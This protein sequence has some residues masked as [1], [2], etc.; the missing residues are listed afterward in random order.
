MRFLL[1]LAASALCAAPLCAGGSVALRAGTIHTSDGAVHTG[2]AVV[3]VVDGKIVA[4]GKDVAVPAGLRV[5]DYGPEAVIVPGLVAADSAYGSG[6]GSGRTADL[7]V[8]AVEGFDQHES[9]YFALQQGVTSAYIAPARGRLVAG[10]GAV[11]KLAGPIGPERVVSESAAVH[12]T[13]TAEARSVRGW[14]EPPIPATI[15]VGLGMEQAQLPKSLMGA[16]VALQELV[17]LG[18]GEDV[19][20]LEAEYG[21]DLRAGL[22]EVLERK[23]PW[24]IGADSVE[25]IRA[26]IAFAAESGL[27][28]ILDGANQAA[29]VADEIAKSGLAVVV[30]ADYAP[31][32]APRDQGKDE[33][34][35]WRRYDA[36]AELA[37]RGVKVALAPAPSMGAHDTRFAATLLRRGGLSADDAL[38]GVTR[39]AAEV[40]GVGRR[41]GRL[42]PGFD[43]D[44]AVFAG[45]PME[46]G[47][48]ALAT[49]ID[50]ELAFSAADRDAAREPGERYRSGAIVLSVDELHVG[51]GTVLAPGELLMRDGRIVEVGRK[52][53]R[54][55]GA[56][57]V[58]GKAAMPGMIDALGHLGLEGSN[59]GP[60]PR[61]SLARVVEPGDLVD[62]KV[63][64]AGVTT[65]GLTPR[66]GSRGGIPVMAYKPAA[67]DLSVQVV[68]DPCAVRLSWSA[69]NRRESGRNIVETLKKAADYDKKWSE[70]EQK[71]AAYTPPKAE[72]PPPPL[73]EKKKEEA[74]KD[75]EEKKDEA[76][77]AEGEKKEEPK[78][79]DKKKKKGEEEPPKPVTG[80]W[81]GKLALDGAEARI[82][83]LLVEEAGKV[84]GSLRCD[85][86]SADLVSVSG[87]REGHKAP[88]AGACAA[89]AVAVEG[90]AKDGKWKAKVSVGA[91]SA[92]VELAQTATEVL[93]ARRTEQ[94]KEKEEKKDE[95]KGAPKAPGVD[96]ELEPLRRAMLGEAAV[97][98]AVQREDEILACVD[99]FEAHGIQP[100][101]VGAEDAWKVLDR[102]QGRVAGVLLS[103]RIQ[104]VDP[105][106]GLEPINRYEQLA[107][108]G[109]PVAFHSLAEEGAADLPLMAAY[110]VSQGMG[111]AAALRA[112]TSDAARILAID[113]K[114]GL[115]QP[116]MDADVLLL[117]G[118][119]LEPATSVLRAFV[120]GKEIR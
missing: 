85:L 42:A 24:R 38:L 3:V 29:L 74:K 6:Q 28:I 45:H 117:D 101:L 77:S 34:A 33:A 82:R 71:L 53:G 19:A 30:E 84:E 15:D 104:Y 79:E 93:V 91:K 4:V 26:L 52:V 37:R 17:R 44:V 14:W 97:L 41:L 72:P 57:V 78:K 16:I 21:P 61:Q 111:P 65:V 118:A 10:H 32:S 8:K 31:N 73:P 64:M 39:N 5:V 60:A 109:I 83:L 108:A 92:E 116:G 49:W 67:D 46:S 81:E 63:A 95:P 86:V 55:S 102:I 62:R 96:P 119:P 51:D 36:A 23:T 106:R 69:G 27:P 113:D 66:S 9:H 13:I 59:R 68:D 94:R 48:A 114:V 100:V 120:A 70:Y 99:A 90:E 25:E 80:A 40:L 58:R 54:P 18:K 35:D 11:V 98:V 103:Q 75:G 12:G 89:G 107:A 47:S 20:R 7:L 115:L 112:L 22:V 56:M 76:K 50:G 87:A 2:G 43:G 1:Q 110:A 88:L 105:T